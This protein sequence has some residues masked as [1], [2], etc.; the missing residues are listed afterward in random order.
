MAHFYQ[1]VGVLRGFYWISFLMPRLVGGWFQR[2]LPML[3]NHWLV[4]LMLITVALI[5]MHK[6]S[7]QFLQSDY[8]TKKFYFQEKK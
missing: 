4:Q 6:K 7:V 8:F 2:H 5:R 1:Y 3:S